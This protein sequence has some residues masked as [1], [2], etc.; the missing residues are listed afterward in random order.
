MQPIKRKPYLTDMR[1]LV[2]VSKRE[3]L[4]IKKREKQQQYAWK[5]K[6]ITSQI[7]EEHKEAPRIEMP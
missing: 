6:E 7:V 5:P 4:E 2:E 3:Q 1:K